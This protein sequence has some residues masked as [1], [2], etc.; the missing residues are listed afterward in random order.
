MISSARGS[1]WE[2]GEMVRVMSRVVLC[3][4]L[5]V[6]AAC[7]GTLQ[8]LDHPG[9]AVEPDA[10]QAPAGDVIIEDIGDE[11]VEDGVGAI[12]IEGSKPAEL[13]E[14]G[15]PLWGGPRV[16]LEQRF[17]VASN[18]SLEQYKGSN[19]VLLTLHEQDQGC[20][21]AALRN[22]DGLQQELISRGY[23]AHVVVALL[24]DGYAGVFE[25][26]G[27][28]VMMKSMPLLEELA[29]RFQNYKFELGDAYVFTPDG[30]A[31]ARLASS[32]LESSATSS[33]FADRLA[34]FLTQTTEATFP[35]PEP[36]P[37]NNATTPDPRPESEPEPEPENEPA[38]MQGPWQ[39]PSTSFQQFAPSSGTLTLQQYH[40]KAIVFVT[41]SAN[42]G[43]CRRII[44][45]S[46]D[47]VE[48]E[49][50]NQGVGAEVVF[51]MMNSTA[52]TTYDYT[53]YD[54]VR[55]NDAFFWE[56]VDL[57][58]SNSFGLGDIYLFDINGA[59]VKKYSKSQVSSAGSPS[60]LAAM[61]KNDL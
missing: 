32:F 19:L 60:G 28:P 44:E 37:G 5:L 3:A 55:K 15:A 34:P 33:D 4:S 45:Q 39:G 24:N 36:E 29:G 49:L 57:F 2:F 50:A 59:P 16:T 6:F 58:G 23:G 41:V 35:Q 56:L 54:Q 26:L 1:S 51:M 25:P 22:A 47:G 9:G 14:N 27:Y 30:G 13:D 31:G 52:N 21:D 42:C 7:G 43:I 38:P 20:V 17:P 48:Q 46:V 10:E 61:I 8:P 11:V 40:G 53:G 12:D 18:I